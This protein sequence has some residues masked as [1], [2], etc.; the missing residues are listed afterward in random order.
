[1]YDLPQEIKYGGKMIN[2]PLIS[3]IT[4][5]YNNQDGLEQTIQSIINQ[6]YKNIEYI[7]I[8]G[9]STDG[10]VEIIKKYEDNIEFWTSESDNGIFDAMNKGLSHA[11]GEWVHYLNSSDVYFSHTTLENF[12]P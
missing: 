12:A 11:H 7:I 3:I 6:T 10:T 4:V 9:G 1:L 2:M 8:D 5:S